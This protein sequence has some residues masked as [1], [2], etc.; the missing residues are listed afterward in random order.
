[1]GCGLADFSC[2]IG[3]MFAPLNHE[4]KGDINGRLKRMTMNN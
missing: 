2:H 4:I 3:C 1:M